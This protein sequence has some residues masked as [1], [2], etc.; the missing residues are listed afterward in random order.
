[1]FALTHEETET[2]VASS[3]WSGNIGRQKHENDVIPC[4][5]LHTN[6]F[7]FTITQG[8]AAAHKYSGSSPTAFNLKGN[9]YDL[10]EGIHL[11]HS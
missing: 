1:M 7:F 8:Q 10:P 4:Q 5:H 2:P 11:H 3:V 6:T 9:E